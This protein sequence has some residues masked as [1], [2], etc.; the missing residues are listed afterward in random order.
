M[1]GII[2]KA[3]MPEDTSKKYWEVDVWIENQIWHKPWN[4]ELE[5]NLNK[6]EKKKIKR[7]GM[8]RAGTHNCRSWFNLYNSGI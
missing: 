1:T 6:D 8:G 4:Y 7:T 2:R 5:Q 3:K